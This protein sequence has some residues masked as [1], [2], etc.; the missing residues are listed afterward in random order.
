MNCVICRARYVLGYFSLTTAALAAAEEAPVLRPPRGELRPS[1]LAEHGWWLAVVVVVILLGIACW[2]KW[3][4]RPKPPILT[5]ADVLARSA[6]EPLR[7]N[8]EDTSLVAQVSQ[9]LRHYVIDAFGLSGTEPTTAELHQALATNAWAGPDLAGALSDFLRRCDE[10]KFA[11][12]PSVSPA[13]TVASALELIDKAE[14][15]RKQGPVA[16]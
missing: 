4:H 15:R 14:A 1:F 2:R 9:I 3:L 11:L 5:P 12:V 8:P 10:Q 13:G 16:G 7:N 6:L